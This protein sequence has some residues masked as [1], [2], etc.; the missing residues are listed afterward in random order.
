MSHDEEHRAGP[1]E[2]LVRMAN[3]IGTFFKSK[4][5][6]EGVA[7][8]AEHINK[9]WEPRMRRQFFEIVDAGGGNLLPIVMEASATIRRPRE[10]V[11]AADSAQVEAGAP[12]GKGL[13]AGESVGEIASSQG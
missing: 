4:P 7:G 12:E 13:A 1:G 11:S 8:V 3:Q 6:E 2:K 5:H 9:F 10:P